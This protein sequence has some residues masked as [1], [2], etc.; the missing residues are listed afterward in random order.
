[1]EWVKCCCMGCTRLNIF[2]KA[3][4]LVVDLRTCLDTACTMRHSLGVCSY[5]RSS[6]AGCSDYDLTNRQCVLNDV[7]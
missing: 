3:L 1:M 4:Y 7:F 6:L 2:G 5:M